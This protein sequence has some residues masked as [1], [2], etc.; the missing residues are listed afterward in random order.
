MITLLKNLT[1]LSELR[2]RHKQY[3]FSYMWNLKNKTRLRFRTDRWLPEELGG[4]VDVWAKWM[5][6]IK[7]HKLSFIQ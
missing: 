6:G 4:W 3:E 1:M 2:E 5:K 7:S